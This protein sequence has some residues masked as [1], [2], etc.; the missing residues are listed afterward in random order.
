M[1]IPSTPLNQSVTATTSNGALV[2]PMNFLTNT[3]NLGTIANGVGFVN[4]TLPVSKGG[5]NATS[6]T[7]YVKGNG[8]ATFTASSTVP[9]TD[10]T[11]LGTMSVQNANTVAITGGNITG[12]TDLAI[13]DGGTGASTAANARTNL[14]LGTIATQ[15]ANAVAITGGNI[16]NITDLA[17][18]DGGTGA[19]TLT[20]YVKGNGTAA[21]TAVG[22]IPNSDITGLGTMSTQNASNVTITGGNITGITDLA[23]SDGGTGAS[24][25]T[26]YV[27]GNGTT[28]LL[29]VTTIPNTDI[30]GLGTMSTQ[31]ASNVTIT[32]GNITGITALPIASG[33]TGANT[34]ANARTNLGLGTIATQN[35]NT[36]SITGGNITGITDLAVADG[37]TGASTLTGYIKGNGTLA[38][39]ALG[40][41]PNT[42]I[43]G[44]GNSSTL[45][46]GT[47]ANTVA[48][49]NDSRF[50]DSRTPTGA[51]GG[52]LTGTY[53]NPTLVTTNVAAGTYGSVSSSSTITVD[54]KGRLTNIS[55]NNIQIAQSQVT[56]L[57]TDLAAKIPATDKA[58]ANGVATLDSGGKVPLTQI[59]DSVLGQLIYQG[60]WNASTN[61]PT[62]ANPPASSTKGYYYVVSVAGTQ[63]TI[64]W[65]VGDWIISNGSAWQKIDNTDAVSSV[66]GR[67]GVVT[68]AS[69]DYTATQITYT[70]T[71]NVAATN[72]QS[73]IDELD[74]E[75]L[76]KAANLADLVSPSTARTNLGLGTMS[77]QNSNTVA[78]TGG[79]IAGITDLAVTDGGTGAS[80]L[81][82][83][84]K[85]NGTLAFTAVG[86]IPNTDITGLGSM[87]T[88]NANTVAITGGNITGIT[89]LAVS[90]GGTGASTLTGYVKGSGTAA[91]TAS[92]TIPNTDITGLGTMSTQNSTSIS[93]TG[94]TM[95]N[96]AL[97]TP[98]SGTLTNCVG[99]PIATG[100]SGL[101]AN[102]ATF[103]ATPT[104]ANL[105]IVVTDET[106]SGSLVFNNAATFIAPNLGTP[107]AVVLSNGTGLPLTT[108]VTGTLPIANG[109]TGQTA[110]NPAFNA[111]AP[112]Q[113]GSN[114][115][116]LT[117]DGSN[118][119]WA[120]I[121]GGGTVTSVS[122]T[123]TVSGIS[124]SGNVTTSGSLTLGGT[125][126]LSSPPA[127]GSNVPNTAAFTDAYATTLSAGF[128]NVAS[129]GT[130]TTLTISSVRDWTVTGSSGQTY[131]LPDAT[132]LRNGA[133]FQFNNNQSSGTIVVRNNSATTVATIQSG[134]YVEVILL[135]NATAAGSWDVHNQAPSNVTWSTNTF[136]Y[137]GSIT[138]ATWNGNVVAINRGGTNA[139]TAQLAINNLAGATT[140]GYYLRGNGSNV[141]MSA[142]QAADVPTL[143]QSTTG[144][145]STA[146]ALQTART[147]GGSSFDGTANVTSFPAAGAIGTTTPA[148]GN[149]TSIGVTTQ[150]TGAFTTLSA[151]GNLSTVSDLRVTD[152]GGAKYILIGN[153]NSGGTN[154]PVILRGVN[155]TL[156]I[157]TGTSWSAAGGGTLT[158]I[159]DFNS[160][161]LAVTGALSS[162]GNYNVS[163]G[164]K[165]T[166]NTNAYVSPEDNV[167]GA[168]LSGTGGAY[169]MVGGSVIAGATS[170]GLA[171]TGALAITKSAGGDVASFTNTSSADFAIN[172]T[173]GVTLLTPS[174]GILAFG[175][176]NTERMRLTSA[177][178]SVNNYIYSSQ[179][180]ASGGNYIQVFNST[181]TGGDNTRYAGINFVVGSDTGTSAIRSY[182]TN[183][184]NNYETALTFLTNPSGATQTPTE[185]MRLTS[186]G[187]LGIGTSSPAAHLHVYGSG[188]QYIYN[189]STTTHCFFRQI[190]NSGANAYIDNATIGS[191][192]YFRTSASSSCDTAPVAISSTG[193]AVTGTV[194]ST[195]T[196]TS[197]I[198]T[199]SR[200]LQATASVSVADNAV[201]NLVTQNYGFF[202]ISEISITGAVAIIAFNASGPYI[203]WQNGASYT[204]TANVATRFNV[205]YSSGNQLVI[206]NKAG[207]TA[208]FNIINFAGSS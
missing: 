22:T 42:D 200:T 16:T 39:T 82:G 97:G 75:K 13:A 17:V 106:G 128:T 52:D 45:N 40:T 80:S 83:Y 55:A 15:N 48:A 136:D 176:S 47:T 145:A 110:A 129:A 127:I 156:Q 168:V 139:A 87:S 62:L 29:A 89:D 37:G 148:E 192:I 186:T 33:G 18:S 196:I 175:T 25:L 113:T 120:S 34:A 90:D 86:T 138:S 96:V 123:G 114:G 137:A 63:F 49:G 20:G 166:Q 195:G 197:S 53:P 119:S 21:L 59:P 30:T 9:S 116:Y 146:T 12:I 185:K 170:T 124:L 31:N 10:I 46:V 149:F 191:T 104:S 56:S 14:G 41:I 198:A 28:A 160:T 19:S 189:Q 95:N 152:V 72:V 162:T 78:I 165:L 35:S 88:Q 173:S 3:D 203:V 27:K 135:S 66:F 6:L 7:G 132:T 85:G 182:R 50:T 109:G 1:S 205:Y 190:P 131:Q 84:V 64:S 125:L 151:S 208:S 204:V 164:F 103:L 71:G 202:F 74:S 181:D 70:P 111:L 177:G 60:S 121:G 180:I 43:T 207:S 144:N 61:N 118:T 54:G 199:G 143:N 179:A 23:V 8:T 69:G 36:V 4:G 115:K 38:F 108:G 201:Q 133:V 158:T 122:G 140:S 79:N 154:T 81:T 2:A 107:A 155:A 141:V 172:L 206:Q 94:G 153:Q 26:G 102:V 58:N 147:I 134:G 183:S 194:S 171:V 126:D 76:M 92:S 91:L 101:G 57:V 68:A 73:A 142:I 112:S 99:L 159:A 51:A 44:L 5:T 98:A 188:E 167:R 100:V 65:D 150:G 93:V 184:A 157:G 105:A 117:T 11:G 178:L 161:G 130:V 163:A 24:T 67:L 193:L 32:G 169:L 187:S 174:T 77:V